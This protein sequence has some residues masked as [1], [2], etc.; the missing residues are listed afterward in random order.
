MRSG[1]I[2]HLLG[3]PGVIRH[4]AQRATLMK[5]P[6][7]LLVH[8][9]FTLEKEQQLT[10]AGGAGPEPIPPGKRD[11]SADSHAAGRISR[12]LLEAKG[13]FAARA[14]TPLD[15]PPMAASQPRNRDRNPAQPKP[16]KTSSR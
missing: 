12:K 16:V 9:V 2:I 3:T 1:D 10:I 8:T 4:A 6:L 15:A 11:R 13:T 7:A 14:A 5:A